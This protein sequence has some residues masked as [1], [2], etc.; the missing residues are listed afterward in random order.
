MTAQLRYAVSLS[1]FDDKIVHNNFVFEK[2][3]G[4]GLGD[5]NLITWE[6]YNESFELLN[7]LI[8]Y[9]VYLPEKIDSYITR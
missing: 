9:I 6:N 2:L 5:W 8:L 3:M 1:E 7:Q 4:F